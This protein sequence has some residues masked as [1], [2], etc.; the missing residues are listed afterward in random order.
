MQYVEVELNGVFCIK[1]C[2]IFRTADGLR[3]Y[4]AIRQNF[5]N[6]GYIVGDIRI[7]LIK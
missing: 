1:S 6:Q 5:E 4:A 7:F 2:P 3:D